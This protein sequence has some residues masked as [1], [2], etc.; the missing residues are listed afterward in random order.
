MEEISSERDKEILRGLIQKHYEKTASAIAKKI[1]DGFDEWALKFKKI[2]PNDYKRML[3]EIAKSEEKGCSRD[4]A[5][6]EAFKR[7]TAS[8]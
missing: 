3:E 7:V 1:L 8:A 4:E 5:V 6:L 2:I